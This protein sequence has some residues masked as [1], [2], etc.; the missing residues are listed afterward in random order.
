M[1]PL[2][3]DGDMVSPLFPHRD[4]S[5]AHLH[6]QRHPPQEEINYTVVP[7]RIVSAIHTM[8]HCLMRPHFVLDASPRFLQPSQLPHY[9][10]SHGTLGNTSAKRT[11]GLFAR[12][13]TDALILKGHRRFSVGYLSR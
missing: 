1:V 5:L 13:S 6:E 3:A 8:C 7:L 12:P 4:A 10:F 9:C 2:L 11:A